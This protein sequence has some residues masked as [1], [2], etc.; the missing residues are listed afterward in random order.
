MT[1]NADTM[2][3]N[4]DTCYGMQT[5]VMECRHMLCNADSM[6]CGHRMQ[7][8]SWNADTDME[9]RRNDMECR[10]NDMECRQCHGMQAQ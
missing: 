3:W 4:A 6:E 9:F 8:V 7:T 2:T 10:H 5:H 1:W